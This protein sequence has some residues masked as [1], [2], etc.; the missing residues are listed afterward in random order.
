MNAIDP[1]W[2]RRESTR[3]PNRIDV[4]NAT[5]NSNRL[6]HGP[7]PTMTAR[8]S[9]EPARSANA[10]TVSQRDTLERGDGAAK[11][12]G[13]AAATAA[14]DSTNDPVATPAHAG[15]G[16]PAGASTAA[17][18]RPLA[19]STACPIVAAKAIAS[20]TV[21]MANSAWVSGSIRLRR[22]LRGAGPQAAA[23]AR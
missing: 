6:P 5:E 14:R 15:W 1:I 22:R 12:A 20:T 2:E 9:I 3:Y 10:A 17:R 11:S 21:P 23:P 16:A 7:R 8:T 19:R 13:P 4:A 18:R